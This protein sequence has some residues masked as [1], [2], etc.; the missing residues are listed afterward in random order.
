MPEPPPVPTQEL[1]LEPEL[2]AWLSALVADR[3]SA[4]LRLEFA[5]G[6]EPT[7][8]LAADGKAIELPAWRWELGKAVVEHCWF[9]AKAEGSPAPFKD[10]L[11]APGVAALPSRV[12]EAAAGD[13]RVHYD[14]LG[15][16]Y[17]MLSRAEEIGREERD[18]HG[19]FPAAASHAYAHGY[20]GRPVVDEWFALLRE[21]AAKLWPRMKLAPQAFRV[22]PSHDV[23]RPSECAFDSPS[24]VARSVAGNLF[25]RR[26]PAAAARHVSLW[27][28]SRRRLPEADRYNSFDWLMDVSERHGLMSAFYFVCARTHPRF[29]P[30]YR[31][32]DPRI[33]A[34]IRRINARGHEIGLH[35][36]YGSFGEPE[37][38]ALEARRLF[39]VCEREAVRQDQWGG[40]MHYL[41]W[42]APATWHAWDRAGLG[43]DTTL[44]YADAPGF[45]CGTC[46]DYPAFDPEKCVR[47]ALVVR[48]LVAMEAS[49]LADRY[50]GLGVTPAAADTLLALKDACRRV[51]GTFT[52]LWHNNNLVDA[53]SR[54]LYE[55]VIAG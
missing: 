11:P 30:A 51:R 48:P 12:L 4:E 29:D 17:W 23:D 22:L 2:L 52:L 35:P 49:V 10:P 28:R 9:D 34:L 50:L 46:F 18:E 45:R 32:T 36:S 16:A 5:P 13:Y 24:Q 8:R 42:R 44:T 19:R 39:A 27:V 53:A 1:A 54:M 25:K 31:V 55:T 41:R 20:L 37:Q 43:Y 38:I 15:L 7:Y 3:V 6:P 47:L 21:I 26:S 40:R 33:R 14:A